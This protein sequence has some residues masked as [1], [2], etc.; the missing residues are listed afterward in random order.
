MRKKLYIVIGLLVLLFFPLTAV[1]DG[2]YIIGG[3]AV[4]GLL[5]SAWFMLRSPSPEEKEDYGI[6]DIPDE[7]Y[8]EDAMESS[9]LMGKDP[10]KTAHEKTKEFRNDDR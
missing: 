3:L 2:M 5:A 10:D 9:D 7:A 6:D 4:L 8:G 1:F